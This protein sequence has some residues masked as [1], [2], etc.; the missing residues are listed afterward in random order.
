MRAATRRLITSLLFG[1]AIA[2]LSACFETGESTPE[3]DADIDS[4]VDSDSDADTDSDSDSDTDTTPSL[5]AGGCPGAD[6]VRAEIIDDPRIQMDGPD[7]IGGVGDALLINENAAFIISGID[8]LK[9]YWHYGGIPVDAV[10][11]EGCQQ[12]GPEQFEEMVL[13]MGM[14]NPDDFYHSVLRGFRGE[15][16]EVIND[17]AD[18]KAAVVRVHGVDDRFWLVDQTLTKEAYLSGSPRPWSEPLGIELWIDYVLEPGSRV[19]R[20]E[21]N[22][23][24]ALDTTQKLL[25]GTAL[26]FGDTT[27][28]SY[29]A[30]SEFSFGGFGLETG[31]PWLAADSRSNDGA[32]AVSIVEAN[33]GTLNIAGV[34]GF[35]DVDQALLPPVLA[36]AGEDGDTRTETFL[37]IVGP[38]DANSAL[39][40]IQPLN[41]RAV[42][43]KRYRLLT[44]E[45][46]VT[47]SAGAPLANA[48]I[49]VELRNS[50]DVFRRIDGMRSDAEGRF[51]GE[52][53][54]FVEADLDYRLV[55]WLEG[56]PTPAPIEFNIPG[57]TSFAITF[58]SPGT[59]GFDIR[60]GNGTGLP[61]RIFLWQNDARVFRIYSVSGTGE[62]VLPAGEYEVSVTRG[63]E[64]TT[65][66]GAVTIAAGQRTELQAVLEHVV[67]TTG[68]LSYDGHLHGGPSA[69]SP[70][71]IPDR[72]VTCAAEGLEVAVETDHEVIVDWAWG[73]A[74]TGL[75]DWIG[76]VVGQE[77][78][79][80][81]PEHINMYPVE[82]DNTHDD[83]GGFVRWYGLDI[84]E[85]YDAIRERGAEIIALNHPR[86]GSGYLSLI[87]W[88][89]IAGAPGVADITGLGFP[90]DAAMWSWNFD[91]LEYMNGHTAVFAD[92]GKGLFD[93]W[94]SFL[95]HGHRIVALGVTDTH[96]LDT[97]GSPR[98][99]FASSTDAP[100]AFDERDLVDSVLAGR[101]VVSEGAFARVKLNG[102]AG[103]GD[104]VTD[105]DGSVDLQVHVEAIPEIDV[106]HFKVFL[107]C[108]EVA[109]MAA[110][111][112][113]AVV[114]YDGTIAI[115]VT[116][117][118]HL[119]VLGFG[120]ERFPRGLGQFTPTLV[121][122]FTTNAIY[123]DADGDGEWTHPGGKTCDYDLDPPE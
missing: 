116:Q 11:I 89:R 37:L 115:P 83:R 25:T 2:S 64:Y 13:L 33:S 107:N 10:A 41:Q 66:Q 26:W 8:R 28:Q 31:V 93:D 100:A 59:L 43:G 71:L 103:L 81:L 54:D 6:E 98:T 22:L 48:D 46:T 12:A 35:L 80:I 24:N 5:F 118:A 123:I 39:K 49:G 3:T 120:A 9:T 29:F 111:D 19:L 20:V 121:P 30:S 34:A 96:Y 56:W 69:D 73:V 4:D 105:T 51:S 84:A 78:T 40:H 38:T 119:V 74:A 117:D 91:A 95:N 86:G 36:P 45:G 17:G 108:D 44:I 23:K 27:R 60:D 63:Y 65:Y 92:G 52:I 97:P 75:Q 7:A 61:A 70:I 102:T 104:T 53:P 67:D 94:M 15:R 57:Q 79:C 62:Q 76:T 21:L 101:L 50:K 85:V 14:L 112:P 122:R 110:D 32:W 113:A 58:D 82:V 114:K 72:I 47:D 87:E 90:A 1:L 42:P 99:Y 68:F 55:P 77:V 109:N 106:T 16:I 88:D 18:G